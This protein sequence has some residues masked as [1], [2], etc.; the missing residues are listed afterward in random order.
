MHR[1]HF[2]QK[3]D[4]FKSFPPVKLIDINNA[5]REI[6]YLAGQNVFE[7]GAKSGSVYIVLEGRL[8]METIIEIDNFFR[9]PV[10]K[11][12][13]EVRKRTRRI[14]YKLQELRRADIFGHEELLIGIDRRTRVRALTDCKL[15]YIN[16]D[17]LYKTF[18]AA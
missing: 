8:T 17:E 2:L 4:F 16:R 12:E 15:I 1:L 5:M 10:S 6:K 13:W 18:P 14:Q 9:F 11:T 3:L 7:I